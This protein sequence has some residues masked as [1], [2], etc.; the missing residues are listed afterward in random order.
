M[1]PAPITIDVISDVMCPWCYI[2]KRRLKKA[3]A[4]TSGAELD[5]RW[6]PFQLDGT[7]P[8]EGMD[9]QEYL[10][11]KFGG[12]EQAAQVYEPVRAA[13]DAEQIPFAFEA[14][15]VSPN[16]LNA[17]RMIRWSQTTGLQDAMVERLFQLY[18]IEGADLTD[19]TVLADAAEQVGMDRAIVERLLEGDADMEDT[20]NEIARAQEMGVTG[21]PTFIIGNRYVVQGAQGPEILA[22]AIAKVAEEQAQETETP[23][24]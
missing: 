23:V 5:I 9:R 13:G 17:H 8:M 2:G 21:V 12:P 6:R 1:S 10:S 22:G 11:R 3:V 14:I 15:K 24:S 7:I 20:K 4:A 18:F 19:K 16:T